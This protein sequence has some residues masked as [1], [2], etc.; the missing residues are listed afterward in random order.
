MFNGRRQPSRGGTS[1]MTR[2]CQVRFYERLGVKFPGPTRQNP[3]FPRCNIAGRFTS[4][5]GPNVGEITWAADW[6]GFY[7]SDASC[8]FERGGVE[9]RNDTSRAAPPIRRLL[10]HS[11]SALF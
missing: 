9:P 4:N 6:R 1:R 8:V 11:T 7:P 3:L 5:K 2:E 10:R